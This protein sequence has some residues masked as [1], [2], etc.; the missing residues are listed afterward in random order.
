MGPSLRQET[1]PRQHR[2]AHDFGI[3]A[4]KRDQRESRAKRRMILNLLPGIGN[5]VH[6]PLG[7]RQIDEEG[8]ADGDHLIGDQT[9]GV[10]L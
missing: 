7:D 4:A 9:K 2:H 8:G 1:D 10:E 6:R 5:V 3:S